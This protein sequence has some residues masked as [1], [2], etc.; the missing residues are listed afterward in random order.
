LT[1]SQLRSALGY[2]AAY[3]E[4]IDE[5]I[6]RNEAWTKERLAQQYPDL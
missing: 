1:E 2:Y 5:Q 3:R 6:D 4:E